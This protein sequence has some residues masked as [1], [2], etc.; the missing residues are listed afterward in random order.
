MRVL[1][2]LYAGKLFAATLVAT[3]SILISSC[4][5]N[6]IAEPISAAAADSVETEATPVSGRKFT[7]TP[8]ANGYLSVNNANGYYKPG[9]Q[10][11]LKGN[12][13]AVY[14]YNMSGSSSMPIYIKNPIGGVTTIGNP[15]WSGGSYAEG[16]RFSNCHYIKFGSPYRKSEFIIRGSVQAARDA[17]FDL[18]LTE[19]TDNVE[20]RNITI[21]GGGTGIW[22][23]TDPVKNDR[24][25]WYPNATMNNLIIRGCEVTNTQNEAMY[26]GHTATYYDLTINLSYYGTPGGFTAGH[27]YVQPIKWNNV[28]IYDN[29]VH[30]CGVDGIQTAAINNLEV[31]RNEVKNWAMRHN[32]AH[33]GGILIGGRVTN[34]NVHDN[35]VHDGWGELLQ[36]YGS[37]PGHIIRN[38]LFRDN[39]GGHDGVSLRGTEQATITISNNT[40]AR[41]GG[42]SIRINGFNGQMKA[43]QT[44]KSNVMIQPRMG[45]APLYANAYIYTEGG[46][47]YKEGTG[48]LAN[49]KYA[50]VTAA[51][52]S[53]TNFYQPL[54]GST[55][56]AAGYHK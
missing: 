31:F 11:F 24:S 21:T 56:G 26:I 53:T 49:K 30:D 54:S 33:N 14:F 40:I 28:K 32:S 7:L 50:T 35:Y 43:P 51:K 12:F 16:A 1:S 52:V 8:D 2:Q 22:A 15:N 55:I 13:K 18:V 42:N 37:G 5:K 4:S 46:G 6:D 47:S 45:G 41:T 10:I 48:T 3:A 17:Y 38:N 23:K 36:F 20:L 9:D 29:Y 39:Q 25:T 19:K 44:I 34:S 27:Q